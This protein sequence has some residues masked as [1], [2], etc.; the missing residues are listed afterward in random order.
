MKTLT[1]LV[2]VLLAAVVTAEWRGSIVRSGAR[3][4]LS[5]TNIEL[6]C[7]LE[8]TTNHVEW[9]AVMTFH[10]ALVLTNRTDL[11]IDL[12]DAREAVFW[13]VRPTPD[14]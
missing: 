7:V 3:V 14:P 13:R 8:V 4:S 11:A 9:H 2:L 12:A 5:W 10:R 1:V 6:P